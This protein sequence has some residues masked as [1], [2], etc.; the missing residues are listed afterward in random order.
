ML[1]HLTTSSRQNILIRNRKSRPDLHTSTEQMD[2]DT[3]FKDG[4]GGKK[5]KTGHRGKDKQS[6]LWWWWA[7]HIHQYNGVFYSPFLTS[8]RRH[9]RWSSL[10][11][12]IQSCRCSP[13]FHPNLL[14]I[15]FTCVPFFYCFTYTVSKEQ[16]WDCSSPCCTR[17]QACPHR[18]C[19]NNETQV[20]SR[21]LKVETAA[22]YMHSNGQHD[23]CGN[24]GLSCL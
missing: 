15:H 23:R 24:I 4:R 7:S 21:G 19:V 9:C 16:L 20:I 10:K 5:A 1:H 8:S 6:V 14:P 17:G 18:A 2:V 12:F 11:D 22:F 3:S 13:P